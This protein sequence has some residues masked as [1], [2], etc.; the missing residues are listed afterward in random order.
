MVKL[1][2]RYFETQHQG[3]NIYPIRRT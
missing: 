2:T 1:V 3:Q